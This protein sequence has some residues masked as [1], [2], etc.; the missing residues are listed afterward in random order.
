[1]EC[2]LNHANCWNASKFDKKRKRKLN[3]KNKTLMNYYLSISDVQ[4]KHQLVVNKA[5]SLGHRIVYSEY[6][7]QLAALSHEEIKANKPKNP[8]QSSRKAILRLQCENHPF[9]RIQETTVSNSL[10][11]RQGLL[12][13]GR[14]KVSEKLTD[15]VFSAETIKK[16]SSSRKALALKKISRTEKQIER[17][18]FAE[19]RALAFEKGQYFCAISS[20]KPKTLNAHHLFS[21]KAFFSIKYD[22]KNSVLLDA[23]IHQLFHNTVGSLNIVT[24]DHFLEFLQQLIDDENFRIETFQRVVPR[25]NFPTYEQQI[26]NNLSF[27]NDHNDLVKKNDKCSETSTYYNIETLYKLLQHMTELRPKLL[28]KL[29]EEEKELAIAA[30]EN[31]IVARGYESNTSIDAF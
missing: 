23:K 1:M 27:L 26:S 2:S 5:Q 15:R 28:S 17:Q 20:I 13:C 11:A 3:I 8:F 30:F 22:P 10:R 18:R 7:E 16:M 29:T 9:G 19:W 14:Q 24:I 25:K 6:G 12:C 4:K 31:S 21:K